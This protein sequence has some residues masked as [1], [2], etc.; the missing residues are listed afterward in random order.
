MKSN[1]YFIID[2]DST[3]TKVE[4]LDELAAISLANQDNK[5]EIVGQIKAITDQG[6]SGNLPFK[7]SLERRLKLLKANK[8]HLSLLVERLKDK[9]SDSMKRNRA[10]F[11]DFS[12]QIFIISSGFKEFIV[13]IVIEF[14]IKLENI[15]ANEFIFNE[16]D[17][18]ID[19]KRDNPLSQ[20]N[21]KVKLIA[22]LNLQGDVFVIGDGYT[23]Y[24]IRKAGLANKFYAFTE[25][26]SREIVT[27]N[28]DH[29]VPN[30][31][32][33]LYINKLPMS[34]SYPKNRINVLLFENIHPEAVRLFEAEGY[35]VST[36]PKALSEDELCEA[37][38]NVSI[39][40][41][42]SKTE[43]TK[44]VLNNANKL[45]AIGAFCIGTNQIDLQAAMEK[46]VAVFNAPYSNTRSVV[47]LAIGEMIL[48]IRNIPDKTAG[49]HQ[50][51]WDK[52][53]KNSFEI[54]GKKL[55][56]V[57][58][59]NIGAQLSVVAEALGMKVYY[60]DVV[61]KLALGNATKCNSLKELLSEA[62]VISLHVD[63][64]ASNKNL[65]GEAEFDQMKNGVVFLNLARGSVV[66]IPALVK[67]L[68]SGKIIGAGIDVFPVE[69]NNNEEFISEL[70]GMK[71]VILTPHIGGSTAEAQ[72]NIGNFVAS[73]IIDYINTGNTYTS[74][75]FPTIQL[76]TLENAHR[77]MHIHKNTSGIL[78]KINGILAKHQINIAGQYLK[79]NE[80]IGYVITDVDTDYDKAVISD[81]RDIENTIKF[82]LLY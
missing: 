73:K 79:T 34:V 39:L 41:I 52:S 38:K 28:A 50:G 74:V 4:G 18:I 27:E 80:K 20:D 48:L 56:I 25:N 7:E 6:M 43:I 40:G 24:E 61:E 53:A 49:M 35:N 51:I 71:N 44:K 12:D 76:P 59:G 26:V 82:R 57:G 42:R 23:D 21:G 36:I 64:R 65:I 14:G 16:N 9:V 75:N 17:E 31:D 66:N 68:Q 78:A 8:K 22:S 72:F 81:L 63:G 10:F 2:F 1:K 3:F 47:E 13:P 77:L 58:Y 45:I 69:P 30:L 67:N 55:G 5:A 29:V 54:R 46:G 60:Y 33:F 19:F 70:R 11:E 62:D 32:E 15:Y 37:V